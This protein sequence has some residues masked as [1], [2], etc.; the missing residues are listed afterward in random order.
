MDCSAHLRLHQSLRARHA[1]K[2]SADALSVLAR[3]TFIAV[4]H[5]PLLFILNLQSDCRAKYTFV[6]RLPEGSIFRHL[7]SSR[8]I[9]EREVHVAQLTSSADEVSNGANATSLVN[10]ERTTNCAKTQEYARNKRGRTPK[11]VVGT[12]IHLKEGIQ[13]DEPAED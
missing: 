13:I 2:R 7:R 12:G 9:S 8:S 6:T 1:S 3:H 11:E 5:A 10:S 4:L